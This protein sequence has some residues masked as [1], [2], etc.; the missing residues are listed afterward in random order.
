MKED[1]LHHAHID[2]LVPVALAE[3]RTE[4]LLVLG[5]KLSE[6]PYSREDMALLENVAGA[7]EL[8]L[9]GG[10]ASFLGRAF[11]ECPRCGTCYETGTT[12]CEVEGTTL[13]L[14]ASPRLLVERYRLE[15]R[16][17]QDRTVAVEMIRDEF[18]SEQQALER[19][20]RESRVAGSFSHPNIV[21]VHDFG[22][23]PNQRAFL[24]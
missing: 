10:P 16:L 17:G 5:M 7:I 4:A 24:V 12:R 13:S 11:E 18:F 1:F 23:D 20:R 15:K 14:V 2:L 19:F 22:V 8:L 21:T 6:E 3:G 9:V